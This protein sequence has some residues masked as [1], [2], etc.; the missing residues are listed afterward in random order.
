[1]THCLFFAPILGSILKVFLLIRERQIFGGV[2][3]GK[4]ARQTLVPARESPEDPTI[5]INSLPIF[6]LESFAGL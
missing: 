2:R 1:M 5:T 3:L 6:N 4:A